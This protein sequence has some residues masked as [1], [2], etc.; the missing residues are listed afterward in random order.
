MV[1]SR[2]AKQLIKLLPFGIPGLFNPW[3]DACPD[4]EQWNGPGAKLRRLAAHL[5]CRP[6]FI[7]CGEAPGYQGCRHSGIAFTSEKL[8]LAGVVPRVPVPSR[9]LTMRSLP[10]SEPSATIVWRTLGDLGI[11]EQTVLWNALQ[12]H[13]HRAG[14]YRSNRTPSAREIALG[15]PSLQLLIGAFPRAKLIAVGKKAE[16]LMAR[17]GVVSAGTVRHPANGGAT[18]FADQMKVLAV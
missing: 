5:D 4:D 3:R 8:L 9:R 12:L 6:R 16:S 11:A 17:M 18:A 10:F 13:P 1:D 7:L 2:L 15:A 14:D